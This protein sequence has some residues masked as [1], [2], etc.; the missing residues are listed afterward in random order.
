MDN[1]TKAKVAERGRF[2]SPEEAARLIKASENYNQRQMREA[3]RKLEKKQQDDIEQ[4]YQRMQDALRRERESINEEI[5]HWYGGLFYC[6][7]ALAMKRRGLAERTIKGIMNNI[8]GTIG[9]LNRGNITVHDIKDAVETECNMKI[10][11]D[12]KRNLLLE[13]NMFEEGGT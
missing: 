6:L 1:Y 11:F 8:A 5:S 10:V 12:V 13:R 7:V 4:M 2:M 3:I 9:D